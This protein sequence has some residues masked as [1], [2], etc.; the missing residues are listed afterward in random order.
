MRIWLGVD[1][2]AS[3]DGSHMLGE[4]R[5]AMLLARLA[6]APAPERPAGAVMPAREA[7]ELATLG[8]ASVLGRN[9]IGSLEPG[10]VADF[11]AVSLDRLE[12]A[13]ALHDPVAALVLCAPVSVDE[14]WV[15]GVP[16]V[17]GGRLVAVDTDELIARHNQLA[18]DLLRDL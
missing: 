10:K 7:L 2:S 14:T 18:A 6:A 3:N 13:G 1:G 16:V 17:R 8:G 12:Y 15:D 11:F 9:D 5:Q 4:V